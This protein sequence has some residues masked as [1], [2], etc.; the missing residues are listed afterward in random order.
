[1][2]KFKIGI[3]VIDMEIP[4]GVPMGGYMGR[5]KPS[6]G[7]HDPLY[8][9]AI[10]IE[11][12]KHEKIALCVADVVG[13]EKHHILKLKK[14]LSQDLG[15]KEEN[16][17]ISATHT[18]AGPL[19][20]HL[21]NKPWD[22]SDLIYEKIKE[23]LLSANNC[24][25]EGSIEY[26]IGEISGVSFNRRDF[27]IN[28]VIVNNEVVALK[29]LDIKGSLIAIIYN[30]SN[31]CVVMN[32]TNLIISQ[33]WPYY[34]AQKIKES[35]KS[36]PKVLFFQGTCGNLNPINV[37]MTNPLHTWNDVKKIGDKT[38]T[39]LLKILKSSKPITQEELSGS[40]ENVLL[41]L[42]D[43]DKAEIFTFADVI[44]KEGKKFISSYCQTLRIGE[45]A[46]YGLPG[47]AFSEIGL[48]LKKYAKQN[49]PNYECSMVI[50]YAN[51]YIGYFGPDSAYRAGGYEMMV[52]SSSENEGLLIETA[53]RTALDKMSKK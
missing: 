34:T 1:M 29:I 42:E 41:D 46:I 17:L 38:A 23:A 13:L 30:F 2:Q 26:S 11:N 22:K 12:Q 3:A 8:A 9:R 49:K 39:Q 32:D 40:V 47:E 50:G 5:V 6:T 44:E 51:D 52:M 25:F 18:H 10:V 20:I 19:N 16:I 48:N 35:Y 21:F 14:T 53:A 27:D 31:H 7:V 28:S 43:D 4:I 15:T 45:L 37:P 33:D 24:M 36:N